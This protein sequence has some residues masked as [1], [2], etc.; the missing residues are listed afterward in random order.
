MIAETT[1]P[2]GHCVVLLSKV[3]C[4][5]LLSRSDGTLNRGLFWLHMHSI[6]KDPGTPPKVVS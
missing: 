3:T 6:L 5:S 1:I 2:V 4:A